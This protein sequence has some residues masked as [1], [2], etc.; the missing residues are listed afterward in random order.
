V[1][2]HYAEGKGRREGERLQEMRVFDH[3]SSFVGEAAAEQGGGERPLAASPV[4]PVILIDEP[5]GPERAGGAPLLHAA[6]K[7]I[8]N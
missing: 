6:L 5:G 3:A 8:G 7:V 1:E 2:N 4:S